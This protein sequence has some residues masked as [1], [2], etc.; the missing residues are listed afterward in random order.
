MS[1]FKLTNSARQDLIGIARHTEKHWGKTQRNR[2]LQQL[3]RAFQQLASYPDS[4][5]RCDEVKP[6]YRKMRHDSHVIFYKNTLPNEILI[7]RIL[8][9]RMDV[10]H[11]L[12]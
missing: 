6:G 1:T 2:Y 7:V 3:D 5:S 12:D 4:G 10:G 11:W 8:H 9:K